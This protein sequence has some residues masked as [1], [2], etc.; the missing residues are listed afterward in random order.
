MDLRDMQDAVEDAENTLRKVNIIA[1]HLAKLLV[2]R[3]RYVGST[4]ALKIF[5]KELK[6]FNSVTGKWDE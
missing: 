2:G 5:K 3:L 4:R 1:T 6:K